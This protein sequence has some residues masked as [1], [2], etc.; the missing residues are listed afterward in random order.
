MVCGS[1][2][3]MVPL[4]GGTVIHNARAFSS[5]DVRPSA[6]RS[7]KPAAVCP[8]HE[9]RAVEFRRR[10]PH[11]HLKGYMVLTVWSALSITTA[12]SSPT[13]NSLMSRARPFAASD[14]GGGPMQA[15]QL[16]SCAVVG[17]AMASA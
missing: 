5:L 11:R 12:R 6:R 13:P 10:G 15:L 9:S 17:A 3:L 4:R 2:L 1:R 16:A 7:A 8:T 14:I